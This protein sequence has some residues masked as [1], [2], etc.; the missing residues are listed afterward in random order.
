M[1]LSNDNGTTGTPPILGATTTSVKFPDFWSS[2]SGL[3]CLTAESIFRKHRIVW[4]QTKFDYVVSA[5]PEE[6]AAVVRDV[7]HSLL[8]E[9][10]YKKLRDE[11][12]RRR[13]GSEPF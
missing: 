9:Q 5:L 6:T 1:S 11:R 7:V 3:W 10:P 12:I 4:A 13:T 8:V 2:N